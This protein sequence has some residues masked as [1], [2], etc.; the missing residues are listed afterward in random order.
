MLAGGTSVSEAELDTLGEQP[1]PESRGHDEEHGGGF[2]Q[3]P[4][5]PGPVYP[6]PGYAGPS[7]SSSTAADAEYD[8][9]EYNPSRW[10]D[11]SYWP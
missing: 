8:Y 4:E 3:P 7:G 9:T 10:E 1:G 2:I 5:I 6:D 11:Y